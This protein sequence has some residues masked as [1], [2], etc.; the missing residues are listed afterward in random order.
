MNDGQA[1]KIVLVDKV[2]AVLFFVGLLLLS[3][4]IDAGQVLIHA[5]FRDLPQTFDV[6]F[7]NFGKR[8]DP[9][10][11]AGVPAGDV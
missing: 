4:S 10:V 9:D 1:R 11:L 6:V 7:R 3:C 2:L 8:N 5:Q